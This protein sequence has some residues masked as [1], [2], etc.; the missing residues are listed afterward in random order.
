[1]LGQARGQVESIGFNDYFRPGCWT[2][3]LVHLTPT[4]GA[5]FTVNQTNPGI[6][7]VTVKITAFN[8]AKEAGVNFIDG[9]TNDRVASAA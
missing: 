4:T 7:P 6:G 3:M 8:T 9:L 1:M 5:S 2:P